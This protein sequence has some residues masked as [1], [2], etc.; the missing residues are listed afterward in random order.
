MGIMGFLR[1]RM[2]VILVVIIGVA[3]FAF[4]AGEVIT[5]GR[6][7]MGGGNDLGAVA[8]QTITYEEY[9]NRVKQGTEAFL[10]QSGQT[11]V[12]PQITDYI[13]ENTWNQII[14]KAIL[15]KE[16][17]KV[18]V[19]VGADETQSLIS[20][21]N[22]SPQ[23]AQYFTD[24]KT[25]QL[26]RT[27]L[28]E[29]LSRYRT[30]KAGD[31]LVQQWDQL[32][33]G[34]IEQKRAEKYFALLH[35]GLYVN[36]LDA[37]DDYEA[38]NKLAK[39]KYV[40]LPYASVADNK[41][42]V[43]DNDYQDYYNEH[44]YAFKNQ[45]ETRTLEYVTFNGAATKADSAAIRAQLDKLAPAFKTSTNDSLFVQ[46]N[47]E[48]KAPFVY[49]RKGQLEPVLDSVM[50]NAAPGFVYGPYAS[51][52]SFKIAKLVDSRV[53]PDS[54]KARHILL[55]PAKVGGVDKALAKADSIKKVIQGG[56][57]FAEMAK[58]FSEDPQSAEKGGDLGTFGRGAMVPAFEEA[59]FNGKAGEFKI[60][61]SQFG[62]HLIEIESQKGSS[63]VVKV[64]TVDKP[65]APSS[66]T[67]SAAY[68]Q[69]QAFLGNLNKDNF[70]EQAK[71]QKLAVKTAPDVTGVASAIPGLDGVRELVRWAYKS[72]KGD[73]VDQVYTSGDQYVVARLAQVK[74]KGLLPLDVVKPQIKNEV[75]NYVKAKQLSSKLESAVNGA[76]SIEQVAQK[77]GASAVP[78]E[79]IVFANPVIPG[80]SLE[81]EVIGH[82]FGA[83]A[84]KVSKP[85]KGQHGVF[86]VQVDALT[87]P[88]PLTNPVREKQQII[89][90][91][92]QRADG[93]IF[94]ALKDKANVKDNR[95]KFL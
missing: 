25:G 39:F 44:K 26:N 47:A 82:V 22:P 40:E 41:V 64:A 14:S 6:S 75:L 78:V 21:K 72:E 93:Q 80:L 34:I 76:S 8:G 50:F 2:G 73:I 20:G 42:S 95:A 90:T 5:Y 83:P 35:N 66:K 70:T 23:I 28:N 48:T 10:Q 18:G 53:G 31:P 7:F 87:S 79:N 58:N 17:D 88:A 13:Q 92:L 46:V 30:A 29:V 43:T 32:V 84:K 49:Q 27:A 86:V 81:M 24:P 19:V 33:T 59:A 51:N 12:T 11:S 61:T 67:Q 37:K 9:N 77:A 56:K 94:D 52:G 91:L 15:Q 38:K 69:A 55:N 1:E 54:V 36:S 62:V 68:A 65:I 63:K 85:I 3:L 89:Q 71:Q 4:I 45:Q 60:V 16:M 57:T 74:E